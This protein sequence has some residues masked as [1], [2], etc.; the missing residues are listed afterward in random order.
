MYLPQVVLQINDISQHR[1]SDAFLTKSGLF[2]VLVKMMLLDL[3]HI[4]KTNCFHFK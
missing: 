1:I 2:C 3:K 4:Q